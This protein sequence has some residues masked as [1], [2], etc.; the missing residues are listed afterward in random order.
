MKFDIYF[1]SRFND[2]WNN[3]TVSEILDSEINVNMI[4]ESVATQLMV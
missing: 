3:C 1:M 4:D 2:Y